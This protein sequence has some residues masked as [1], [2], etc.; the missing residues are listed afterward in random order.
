MQAAWV[1][2]TID[3]YYD[4]FGQLFS[5]PF[6]AEIRERLKRDAVSRQV[7]ESAGA[8]S[9]ALIR[10]FESKE[11]R[12]GE[13]HRMLAALAPLGQLLDLEDVS[14]PNLA[15]EAVIEA[16]LAGL[17]YPE[18]ATIF[19]VSLQSVVQVLM[20]VGP[21]MAEW[22]RLRFPTTFELPRQVT[23]RLDKISD[24]IRGIAGSGSRDA[25]ERYELEYRDYLLQR[26]H[27]IE[28]GTVRMTTSMGVDLRELFV[29]PRVQVRKELASKKGDGPS[30]EFM[31]LAAAREFL[32]SVPGE[33]EKEGPR[34]VPALDQLK[35]SERNVLIGVPGAGKSTFLEWLQL[36]VAGGEEE[37]V[38]SGK[39][40]IPLLVPVRRLDPRNLPHDRDLIE[41]ATASHDR[42]EL[43]PRGWLERQTSN[44]R[45]MLMLDGLDETEP[46]LRDQYLIPWLRE[47]CT[48]YPRSR[49]VVSSRP[50]GYPPGTFR[51]L[52]FAES[53]LLD[54]DQA[55]VQE[56]ARH[57]CTCVRLAQ[58]E[59][60]AQARRE[61]A[62]EGQ[63]IV[64]SFEGNPYIR[65]LARN[66]LML[67]AICLVNYFEGGQLPK[68]R[69][70]LY[71]LC[72][73]GLLHH[74]DQRRGIQS[75]FGLEE[76][77]RACREVALSMQAEDRAEFPAVQVQSIFEQVFD[78]RERAIRL[79]EHIRLRTGLL[80]ER[81]PGVFA[82]AHLTF[83]EY[84]AALA[85]REGNLG[86]VDAAHLVKQHGDGRWKEV[87]ALYWAGLKESS[88]RGG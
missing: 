46:D 34:G 75:E 52:K 4:L 63:R 62:A 86:N 26:F 87:I 10:F 80:L 64:N 23:A 79:L 59:P 66:P 15:P 49:Y 9:Q 28:V 29:T 65:N 78:D 33:S 7:Q 18:A 24:Q 61:G 44:G 25:D 22:R 73:E 70:L 51:G 84:L 3:F 21:V 50:V 45:V 32:G 1:D 27:R 41:V 74:W 42:A 38:L 17:T 37:F 83:Q 47:L 48:Q 77:L 35:S 11:L 67:S 8:A 88:L 54:F 85:V 76:K 20:H 36:R 60:A 13:V 14:N 69:A 82:F 39:Q 19:R 30:A 53:E 72:V 57:W 71:K 16:K 12:D 43:T 5:R 68:D 58:N 31:T 40:A 55:E 2:K 56:Y 6:A 81:R